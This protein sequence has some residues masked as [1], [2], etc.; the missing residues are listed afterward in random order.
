MKEF[1]RMYDKKEIGVHY[2]VADLSQTE[3][4][5]ESVGKESSHEDSI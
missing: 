3:E 4:R 1:Y 2:N 5:L